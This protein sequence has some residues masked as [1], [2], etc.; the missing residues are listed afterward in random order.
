MTF[1]DVVG[2]K[3]P[4]KA[5]RDLMSTLQSIER[6]HRRRSMLVLPGVVSVVFQMMIW[7]NWYASYARYD[8]GFENN[9]FADRIIVSAALMLVL[10]GHFALM[11]L[12]ESKDRMVVLALQHHADEVK[13][14]D[15]DDDTDNDDTPDYQ[16]IDTQ[17]RHRLAK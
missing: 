8:V 13:P 3:M 17:R 15:D 5:K 4:A 7:F 2:A 1:R 12:S 11:Y 6:Y 16:L 10:A 9:F 14:F